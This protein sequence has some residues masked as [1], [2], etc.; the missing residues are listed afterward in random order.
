MCSIGRDRWFHARGRNVEDEER[1]F[2]AFLTDITQRYE[3]EAQR[4]ALAAELQQAQRLETIGT[5]A[6]GIAHDFNNLLTPIVCA[7][8][9]A[10]FTLP[11]GHDAREALGEALSAAHR[12][13]CLTQQIL[14]FARRGHAD[15]EPVDVVKIV[16]EELRLQPEAAAVRLVTEFAEDNPTVLGDG[17]QLQQIVANLLSNALY[18][19]RGSRGVLR[20]RVDRVHSACAEDVADHLPPGDYVRLTVSDQGVGMSEA[21]QKRVLEPFSPPSRPARAPVSGSRSCTGWSSGTAVTCACAASPA[22]APPSKSCCPPGGP[23]LSA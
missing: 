1:R 17:T 23:G 20:L 10:Q 11:E 5:L 19:M 22:R 6:G 8:E 18:A 9:F 16:R 7:I 13:K 3:A 21:V 12:A 4:R 15:L 14:T 2:F